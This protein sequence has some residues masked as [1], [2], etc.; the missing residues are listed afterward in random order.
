MA[1]PV[2]VS[3]RLTVAG[4]NDRSLPMYLPNATTLAQAQAF[5]TA[6]AVL[7]D[8]VVGAVLAEANVQLPLTLPG[9]IKSAS[10]AGTEL[11][12]GAL[13]DFSASGTS[14][15]HGIWVPGWDL[16]GFSGN[17]VLVS[18][19]YGTFETS[20]LSVIGASGAAPTDRY[21]NDLTTYNGGRKSFRK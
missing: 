14:Y 4:Q 7:L 19:D 21:G 17:D 12:R 13:L 9:G 10:D 5:M 11:R 6:F 8:N 18:G 16:A 3:T 20:L 15:Q 2:I 1:Q